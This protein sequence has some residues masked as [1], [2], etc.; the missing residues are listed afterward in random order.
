MRR[1]HI[2]A[3]APSNLI[4]GYAPALC[5]RGMPKTCSC[6]RQCGSSTWV[7]HDYKKCERYAFFATQRHRATCKTCQTRYQALKSASRRR[8]K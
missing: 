4:F 3:P 6:A 7:V 2:E 8:E 5:G 1:T